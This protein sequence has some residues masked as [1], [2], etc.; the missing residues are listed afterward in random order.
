MEIELLE[1]KFNIIDYFRFL[2]LT[3]D[4]Q[5]SRELDNTFFGYL[6][7][8]LKSLF[9]KEKDYK[10]AIL[11][12]RKFAGSIALYKEKKDYEWG[13]FILREFRNKGIATRASKKI[14]NFAFK[15]LK[16]NKI[17][18]TTDLDNKASQRILR[19]LG[20]KKIKENKKEKELLWE[21]R[22]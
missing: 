15:K 8:G 12:D 3:L 16:L 17:I 6:F 21:K 5:Y 14:L 20:F 4:K 13:Y 11:I 2:G 19:K 7:R 1:K 10:F 22:R 9:R 18:A